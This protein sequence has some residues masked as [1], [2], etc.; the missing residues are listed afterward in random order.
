LHTAGLTAAALEAGKVI[1][2]DRPA[3]FKTGQGLGSRSTVSVQAGRVLRTSVCRRS[4]TCHFPPG[5]PHSSMPADIV[6][7]TIKG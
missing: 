4:A 5:R 6:E 2:L 7:V 3:V 1:V